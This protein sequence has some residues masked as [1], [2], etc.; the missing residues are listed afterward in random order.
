MG[1]LQQILKEAG[2]W[3]AEFKK[4]KPLQVDES[5]VQRAMSPE[6]QQKFLE[7]AASHEAWQVA[8]WYCL[9]ALQTSANNCEMRGLKLSDLNLFEQVLQIRAASAKNKYRIRTIPLLQDALWALDRILQRAR[10]LGSISP[11]DY[12][13]PF[14]LGADAWDPKKPMSSSGIKRSFQEIRKAAGVP[15][16]RIHDLRHCAITRLAEAGTPIQV[17][18]SMAG[19]ISRK[20]LD[21]YTSISVQAKKKALVEAYEPRMVPKKRGPVRVGETFYPA[22]K[23]RR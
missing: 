1:T 23:A 5:D 21:H 17:I 22:G 7:V 12:L 11:N 10:A 6:E 4:Y 18:M 20:M 8:Y 15:W 3:T 2:L 13:F 9:V 19:H 16:L 14:H